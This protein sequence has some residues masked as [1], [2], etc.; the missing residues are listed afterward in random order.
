MPS[1][2]RFVL[3]GSGFGI[4]Q[5]ESPGALLGHWSSHV[6]KG[7][8]ALVCVSNAHG[9]IDWF[10]SADLLVESVDGSPPREVL[11]G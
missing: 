4:F 9:E 8:L 11:G 3:L 7:E 2:E 1:G 6:S 10:P 5:S